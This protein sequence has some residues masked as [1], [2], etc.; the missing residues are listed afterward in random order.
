[1]NA[2]DPSLIRFEDRPADS[3]AVERVW[4]SHSR[5]SGVFQS[6]ASCHWEM[7]VAR[8]EG[9]TSLIVRGPET[10]ATSAVCPADGDWFAIRFRLGTFMPLLRPGQ[11]SNRR[12]AILPNARRRSFWLG[13]SRWE[14]P[15]Y[16]NAETFVQRLVRAELI[17]R[18]PVVGAALRG[19]PPTRTTRTEERHFRQVTG[20]TRGAIVQIERARHATRLLKA[21]VPILRVAHDAGYYDQAHLTR[22]L[23]RWIGL[24]PAQVLRADQQLSFLYKPS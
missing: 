11:L 2:D 3:S 15:S 7:V 24:T 1:V 23:K 16:D 5:R 20:L 14:Y 17:A 8:H 19:E 6:I 18:D 21:G 13:G 4:R 22:G 12:D 9:R 10:I